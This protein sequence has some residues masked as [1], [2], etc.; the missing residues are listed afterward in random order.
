M[1]NKGSV[2][3]TGDLGTNFEQVVQTAFLITLMIIGNVP[4]IPA[5]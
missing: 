2:A 4:C 3:R 5:Y 1:S